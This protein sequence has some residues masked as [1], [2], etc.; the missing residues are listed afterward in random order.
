MADF[1][2][3][4]EPGGADQPG[5]GED[6]ALGHVAVVKGQ[7]AGP[8]VAAD[9]QVVARGGGGDPGPGVPAFALGAVA[10][11]AG[12]PAPCVRHQPPDG[13]GA[14]GLRPGGQGEREVRRDPQHVGLPA[15]LEEL[16]QL[17]AAAVDLVAAD[18]VEAGAVGVRAGA[19]VDGQLPLGAEPQ[20]RRQP[21]EP[22]PGRI[23]DVLSRDPLPGADRRVP[24]LFP[25]VRQ[26]HRVNAVR[27]PA[28]AAQVLPL[29]PR[30]GRALLF[31]P[32]LVDR[33]DHQVPAAPAAAPRGLLQP[34]HREPAH[35][36]HRGDGVPARMVQQP[37]RLIRRPV[38]GITG[39]A[40]PVQ[41]RQLAHHRP[42]VLARLQPR[43]GPGETRP[44]QLQQLSP[45]PQR[46][47]G[48]YPDG[49]SR[50]RFC[51]LHKHMIVRRL[52]LMPG[53]ARPAFPRRSPPQVRLP[54]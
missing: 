21:H 27:H 47:P 15:G 10:G 42:Q 7:V 43:L 1:D 13:S 25:D 33:P 32:G 31:L 38:P 3:P 30:G 4:P 26:V 44:Q 17:G 54:Y 53:A 50:L 45:F 34:G 12:L 16:A 22:G 48:T 8:E 14:R 9:E 20:A 28:R 52:P 19:D 36:A 6:L 35:R 39:D 46:Q 2:R 24:G 49:S 37:L 29:H 40:P 18:E 5:L 23:T 51:C 11:G 41:L